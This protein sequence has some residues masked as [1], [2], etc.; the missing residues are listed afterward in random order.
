M[1]KLVYVMGCLLVLSSSSVLA[2]QVPEVVT[3]AIENHGWQGLVLITARGEASAQSEEITFKARDDYKKRAT[4]EYQRLVSSY[5]QRGFV[6]QGILP[7][8]PDDTY[9]T[10]TLLF[11]KAPKP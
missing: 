4:E 9:P 11:V 5:Y 10:S 8:R 6:L 1:K 2:Q 7:G 3:V